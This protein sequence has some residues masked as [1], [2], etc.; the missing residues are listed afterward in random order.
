MTKKDKT[1]KYNDLFQI[2]DLPYAG[3]ASNVLITRCLN[4]AIKCEIGQSFFISTK[5]LDGAK[6][7]TLVNSTRYRMNRDKRCKGMY[8]K[9]T[10][11]KQAGKNPDIIGVRIY[12]VS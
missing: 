7:T 4:T 3:G 2:D 12:R 5:E 9:S 1:A 10:L 11:I 8:I 6:P